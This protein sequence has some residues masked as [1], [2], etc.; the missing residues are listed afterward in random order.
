MYV[1]GPPQV[2]QVYVGG[3][4][5][6]GGLGIVADSGCAERAL[7]RRV[8]C[9]GVRFWKVWQADATVS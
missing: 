8:A 1:N 7:G 5:G 9:C 4:G 3:G 6:G 2:W